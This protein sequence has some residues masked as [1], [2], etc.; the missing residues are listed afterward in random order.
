MCFPPSF[1]F[2]QPQPTPL[3]QLQNVQQHQQ[4][5]QNAA[6][7]AQQR[8]QQQLAQQAAQLAQQPGQFAQQTG[9]L[10]NRVSGN[11]GTGGGHVYEESQSTYMSNNNGLVHSGGHKLINDNG[12]FTE[13]DFTPQ[14]VLV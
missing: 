2:Q 7:Q 9:V 10:A 6:Q 5:T 11:P 12:K 8:V 4:Q 14:P 13:Y 3:A 1:L